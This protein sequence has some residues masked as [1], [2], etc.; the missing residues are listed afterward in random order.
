MNDYKL[1][2]AIVLIVVGAVL[3]LVVAPDIYQ[4]PTEN[5]LREASANVQSPYETTPWYAVGA[6]PVL[7]IAGINL[8]VAS[9][10]VHVYRRYH[11]SQYSG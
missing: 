8:V 7:I 10:G 5:A 6:V 11:H 4:L 1:F 2:G 3:T 9:I